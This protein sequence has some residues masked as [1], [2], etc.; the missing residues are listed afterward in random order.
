MPN[1]R[2]LGP[3]LV[4]AGMVALAASWLAE[5]YATPVMLF[6]LLLGIAVNFLS[7]DPRCQPGIDFASRSILRLGV[8]L[9]GARI[10]FGQIQSLGGA[11]L[12]LTLGAV[13]CTIGVGVIY[14]APRA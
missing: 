8:A 6:A 13:I 12:V 14:F 3:G 2:S 1:F 7:S 4:I 11:A 5:H 9:L 10:T